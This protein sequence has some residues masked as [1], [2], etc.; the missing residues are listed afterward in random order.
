MAEQ[1]GSQGTHDA[2]E[3]ARVA[4]LV[5]RAGLRLPADE[6]AELVTAYR[7][8]RAGLERL[9]KMVAAEDESVHVFRPAPPEGK[10]W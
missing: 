5:A 9:R 4:G 1:G 7:S 6:I 3:L 8:D 2:E 10:S